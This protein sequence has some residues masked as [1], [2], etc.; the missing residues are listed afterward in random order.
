MVKETERKFLVS[1]DSWRNQDEGILYRQGYIRTKGKVTVRVRIAGD[2]GYLTIKGP[3]TGISR[4]EFEYRIPLADAR[5]MLDS[6]CDK[7]LIEKKRHRLEYKG[8]IWEVDEF[9]GDNAG[10]VLAEIELS[11]EKQ[12]FEKPDWVGAEV[13]ND[14]RYYNA[15]LAENP[16]KRWKNNQ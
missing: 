12:Q 3:T 10:L 16:F 11:D 13:S 7:P 15:S 5:K 2:S 9:F 6:I 14:N 1:G 4:S 8:M